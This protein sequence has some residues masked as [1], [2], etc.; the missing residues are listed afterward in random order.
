MHRRHL[1]RGAAVLAAATISP[2]WADD[3]AQRFVASNIQ[4]GFDILNDKTLSAPARREKF[5]AFLEGVTDIRRVAMFLAG[6]AASSAAPADVDA[7]VAAYRDYILAVYQSYFA[8]YAGQTLQVVSS[9]ARAADDYVVDTM[10][11]GDTPLP[12]SF[13]VRTD[14]G[15]PVLVDIAVAGVWLALAQRDQFSAV[16]TQNGGDIKAL[17]AHLR[18][19]RRNFT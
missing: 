17:S 6:A 18:Q 16:L 13:R 3:P 2:A 1:L 4:T 15:R 12:V 19:A 8:Q 7:Y 5:A 10:L 14:G 11:T 9:R